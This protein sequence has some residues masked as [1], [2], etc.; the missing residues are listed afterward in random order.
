MRA[1]EATPNPRCYERS[2]AIQVLVFIK[3]FKPWIAS[4]L[5]SSQ[6]RKRGELPSSFVG[7][8]VG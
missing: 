2:E 4:T 6:R 3:Y 7:D 5:C 1:D 8:E